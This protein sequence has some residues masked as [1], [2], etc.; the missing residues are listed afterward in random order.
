MIRSWCGEW[1]SEHRGSEVCHPR[2]HFAAFVV[3]LL[4]SRVSEHT[5]TTSL[6]PLASLCFCSPLS[7]FSA[8][9]TA[10][11]CR[12]PSRCVVRSFEHR[13]VRG[14]CRGLATVYLGLGSNVGD[15]HANLLKVYKGLREVQQDYVHSMQTGQACRHVI[16]GDSRVYGSQGAQGVQ[17]FLLA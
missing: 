7:P 8:I 5:L 12:Q 6:P 11:R 1:K 4:L 17:Y 10:D 13:S 3:T 16:V 9:S 14:A 2:V 15:R